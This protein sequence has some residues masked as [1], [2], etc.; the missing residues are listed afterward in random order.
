ML[1]AEQVAI[2]IIKTSGGF[3]ASI[4]ELCTLMIR[5]I[6]GY[7]DQEGVEIAQWTSELDGVH[8]VQVDTL[9]H[10]G[11]IRINLNDAPVW[12]GNPERDTHPGRHFIEWDVHF[13]DR[14][15]GER[16]W[17]EQDWPDAPTR[18]DDQA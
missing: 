3:P 11:R 13:A 16:N 8:V 17:G 12:D 4:H 2:E 5:A 14:V 6:E 1:N 18:T 10:H 15:T 7:V 9:E